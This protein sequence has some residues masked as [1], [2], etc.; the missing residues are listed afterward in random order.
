[1]LFSVSVD[2]SWRHGR[3]SDSP[4]SFA[5]DG[6]G[7]EASDRSIHHNCASRLA[8]KFQRQNSEPEGEGTCFL[9][10]AER[11]RLHQDESG[12]EAEA[13]YIAIYA[14]AAS[15]IDPVLTTR[16]VLAKSQLLDDEHDC[17]RRVNGM[18]DAL[19]PHIHASLS[20]FN[21]MG[22]ISTREADLVP[23]KSP[24]S[25]DLLIL[26]LAVGED[27]A[28]TAIT[29]SINEVHGLSM[30]KDD[31]AI[32]KILPLSH[33]DFGA[34]PHL[35]APSGPELPSCPICLQRIQSQRLGWPLP[36]ATEL[37]CRLCGPTSAGEG[38]VACP[39]LSY[40]K[41][42]PE[43]NHCA[44]CRVIWDQWKP[45]LTEN[46]KTGEA[47]T[48]LSDSDGGG[49]APGC[50]KCHMR[51]T[52]WVCLTCG[53]VGCGRYSRAHAKQH[54]DD[55]L[56]PF[57]MELV[58]HRIWDY[59][60]GE[61]EFVQRGDLRDCASSCHGLVRGNRHEG[62]GGARG[63][64]PSPLTARSAAVPDGPPLSQSPP[65]KDVDG[66]PHY[67][68]LHFGDSR[69]FD[70]ALSPW[71]DGE[72][73]G[74]MGLGDPPSPPS[75]PGGLNDLASPPKKARFIGE[76]YE[77]L[78]QS[79]L[80]DQAQHYE[81]EIT[82]LITALTAQRVDDEKVTDAEA[83]EVGRLRKEIE[84][85]RSDAERLGRD[86]IESQGQEA[87]LRASSQRLLREQQVSKS[88]LDKILE[89][90]AAQR[91]DGQAQMEELQMQIVDLEANIRMMEKIRREAELSE[92][93][94]LGTTS[95]PESGSGERRSGKKG[96][97]GRRSR[98]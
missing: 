37:C 87:G 36:R 78:L 43:P 35:P 14:P 24:T 40:L 94:I 93:Q 47:A 56:H 11:I 51:E 45:P 19:L 15:I 97:K 90:A 5:A 18:D 32:I 84:S 17:I 41:P 60:T 52:L 71:R 4:S 55:T 88:V 77:A 22:I 7:K 34:T 33:I 65:R 6:E 25:I 82:S 8:A 27:D 50:Y 29:E 64:H 16:G 3:V 54:N 38:E 73:S 81:G 46:K 69:N 76:E 59:S 98:R 53:V 48:S 21:V 96:K 31:S 75:P 67:S 66:F 44:A 72:G 12:D 86:L 89:E 62:G 1:M 28:R 91:K 23:G 74:S 10:S 42:W 70:A 57:S 68:D 2:L 95:L 83:A 61:G 13:R 49:D 9:V 79:A 80:E 26:G 92:A 20:R 85:L 63:A 39:N 30:E 58:T